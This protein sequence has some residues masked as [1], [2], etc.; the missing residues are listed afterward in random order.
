MGVKLCIIYTRLCKW[1]VTVYISTVT[2]HR[3]NHFLILFSLSSI[4]LLLFPNHYNNPARQN[5]LKINQTHLLKINQNQPS[6]NWKLTQNQQKINPNTST[7]TNLHRDTLAKRK[8][9]TQRDRSLWER[10]VLD[11]NDR[12]LWVWVLPDRCLWIGAVE[13]GACLIGAVD[14]CL[15]PRWCGLD[16]EGELIQKWV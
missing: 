11:W 15:W 12:S 5:Q 10:S 3:V 2:I 1:T 4:K 9:K 8:K 13:I 7:Q 14:W 16:W 6:I